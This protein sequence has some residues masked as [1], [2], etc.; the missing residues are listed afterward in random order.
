MKL[1]NVN[2]G[3]RN[4]GNVRSHVVGRLTRGR[5]IKKVSAVTST[6]INTYLYF[7]LICTIFGVNT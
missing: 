7:L 4:D 5:N 3:V 1:A 2:C 6:D